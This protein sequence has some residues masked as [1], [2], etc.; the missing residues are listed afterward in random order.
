M[1]HNLDEREKLVDKGYL[2]KSEFNGLVL[3]NYTDKCVYDR[4]WNDITLSSRGTIYNIKDGSIVARAFDKFFNIGEHTSTIDSLPKM[5]FVAEEKVDGSM[6]TLYKVPGE[7]K[8]R[9]AT[10]GSFY[11]E[12]AKMAEILLEQ[13][14]MTHWPSDYTPIVE[15][16]YPENKILI[17]YGHQRKLVLLAAR[18][19]QSGAYARTESVDA[20]AK[21]CKFERPKKES[22][23]IS[24]F[25]E[26][27]QYMPPDREGWVLIYPNGFRVKIKGRKYLELAKFKANLGPLVIWEKLKQKE[28]H[29]FLEMCPEEFTAEAEEIAAVLQMQYDTLALY[30]ADIAK[31][32]N[33]TCTENY[34]NMANIIHTAPQWSRGYLFAIMRNKSVDGYFWNYIR[35]NSNEF[36]NI[37][38]ILSGN[39]EVCK[40]I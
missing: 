28:I 40:S 12:Q 2:S 30:A 13:Y 19:I 16:V 3:Y 1:K 22:G 27:A 32:F 18:H 34:K 33:I 10:R 39:P 26:K 15:I 11:S 6:G 37:M 17:N 38:E 20:L 29:R 25:V 8:W 9:C 23:K 4:Y 14:D 21:A 24:D 7:T 35:P 5:P 36:V 31:T